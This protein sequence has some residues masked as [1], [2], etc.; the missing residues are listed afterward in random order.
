[1][2]TKAARSPQ[3]VIV[4]TKYYGHY[5]TLS[6]FKSILKL[7]VLLQNFITV[8]TSCLGQGN[9]LMHLISFVL[10]YKRESVQKGF[11]PKH[12]LVQRV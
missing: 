12:H 11:Y 9:F 3:I 7:S 2:I 5:I 1:M 8:I 6:S 10:R 4:V